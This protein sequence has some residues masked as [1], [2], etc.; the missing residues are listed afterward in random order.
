[1]KLLRSLAF[2]SACFV[3]VAACGKSTD[4]VF[5][6]GGNDAGNAVESRYSYS[7]QSA[8]RTCASDADCVIVQAVSNCATCCGQG[9]VT[10]GEGDKG[11][12]AVLDACRQPGAPPGSQC[13]LGC[14]TPRP[15]CFEGTCVTFVDQ[16]GPAPSNACPKDAG[17]G[18][19]GGAPSE[20]GPGPACGATPVQN[21]FEDALDPSW[22]T[23]EPSAFQIDRTAPIDGA[24]SLRIAYRQQ[25]A[26]FA[27][28]QPDACG[29]RI[30]FTMRTKLLVSG[31]NLARIVAGDGTWFH[32]R[33]DGCALSVAEEMNDGVA[34]GIGFGGVTWPVP[35]DTAVRVVLT[36]D[37]RGKSVT[38]TAAPIGQPLPE[39]KATPVRSNATGIRSVEIG[40]TKGIQSSA[41]GTVW[42]DDLVID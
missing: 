24:A 1:M 15:G 42:L 32:V 25:D 14:P 19:A 29:I 3:V 38:S 5:S 36:F 12:T 17:A 4:S 6:G 40:S 34:A 23:S 39:P 18:V 11:Y 7:A 26:F 9:A 2:A 21:A 28:A 16:A 33:L 10:R 8:V 31:L 20:L 41:V 27:I 22:T 13:D 30:A 37:I 35:D